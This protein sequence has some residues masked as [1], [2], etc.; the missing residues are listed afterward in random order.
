MIGTS[1][2]SQLYLKTNHY[3]HFCFEWFT[4]IMSNHCSVSTST[5]DNHFN[6]LYFQHLQPPIIAI[7]AVYVLRLEA[8]FMCVNRDT[9]EKTKIYV[10]LPVKKTAKLKTDIC[11]QNNMLAKDVQSS[12]GIRQKSP[13]QGCTLTSHLQMG[14]CAKIIL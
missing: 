13:S 14:A 5:L 8:L 10:S 6:H 7:T 4:R 12:K 11:L 1:M 2:F 9:F 3:N